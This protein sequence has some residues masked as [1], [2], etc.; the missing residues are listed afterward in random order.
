MT[1][2]TIGSSIAIVAC[3][4][5][6]VFFMWDGGGA[7]AR[8]FH[9]SGS[10]IG[11]CRGDLDIWLMAHDII[12]TSTIVLLVCA[13]EFGLSL[14]YPL[15]LGIYQSMWAQLVVLGFCVRGF[16]YPAHISGS[17]EGAHVYGLY[18]RGISTVKESVEMGSYR[19]WHMSHAT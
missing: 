4:R 8:G 3:S 11:V 12:K 1:V 2:G 5:G 18:S 14:W 16:G 10:L 9:G 7:Q 15:L 17:C 13:R 19:L 6:G